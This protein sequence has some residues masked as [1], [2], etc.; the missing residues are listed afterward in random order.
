M[1]LNNGLDPAGIE[2][3]QY[4]GRITIRIRPEL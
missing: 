2:A 4:T 3:K 1:T